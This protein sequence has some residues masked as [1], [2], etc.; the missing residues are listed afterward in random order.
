MPLISLHHLF[1]Q[2]Y[3]P[4]ASVAHCFTLETYQTSSFGF[5][6]GIVKKGF[7][8]RLIENVVVALDI[9][10][11]LATTFKVSLGVYPITEAGKRGYC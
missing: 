3:G 4:V 7:N 1:G 5:M 9:G 2:S 8:F 6:F 11:I 10:R